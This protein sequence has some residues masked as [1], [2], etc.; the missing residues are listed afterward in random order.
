MALPPSW[1]VTASHSGP[2]SRPRMEVCSRKCRTWFGLALQDLLDQVVDD[3]A[4]VPGEAGDEAGDVVSPLHRERRQLER[5]DPPLGAPLQRCDVLCRQR[6]SHHPVEV[7]RGLVGRE[8]QIGGADLDELA[9]PSQPRQRQRRVGAAGDHQVDL[10]GQVLQQEGH[11]VLY[12]ARLDDVV[13][14]EHQHDIVRDCAEVVEQSGQDRFD[15]R[16]GRLQERERTCTDSGRRRL[17]RGDQVRPEHR[18]IVVALVE[19]EPRRGPSIGRSG[20]ASQSASSVVL[21]NPAGADT[22]VSADSAPR[23]R[24][25]LS[26][27]RA[28]RPRRRLGTWSLVSSSGPAMTTSPP[29]PASRAGDEG[30]VVASRWF[31]S[32]PTAGLLETITSDSTV[33]RKLLQL[34]APG[35]SCRRRGGPFGVVNGP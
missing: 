5:G 22:S 2:L 17:Q 19:R 24:R 9:T 32:R 25:S 20:A 30:F 4:V 8:A 26:L 35:G 28:T 11:P 29:G 15:R 23:L 13:V 14:V 31:T 18:G 21:P 27:G 10:R 34:G 6:Q 3:V 7:R 1:P 16:L 12:V 33:R